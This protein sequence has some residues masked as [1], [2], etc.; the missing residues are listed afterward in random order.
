MKVLYRPGRNN[1][2]ADGLYRRPHGT[3]DPPQSQLHGDRVRE[4]C[5]ISCIEDTEKVRQEQVRDVY[6]SQIIEALKNGESTDKGGKYRYLMNDG[7]LCYLLIGGSHPPPQVVVPVTLR[8]LVIGQLHD[9]SG[10]LG[11]HK[12]LEKLRERFY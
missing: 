9:K 4:V 1:G 8:P 5:G 6:T 3:E 11:V 2:N 12:T 7:V 10:H